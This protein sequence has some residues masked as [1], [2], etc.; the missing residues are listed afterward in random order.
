MRLKIKIGPDTKE[1]RYG[2]KIDYDKPSNVR[3]QSISF[4]MD[5]D[6]E[7][8][9]EVGAIVV[10]GDEQKEVVYSSKDIELEIDTGPMEFSPVEEAVQ[11][12][13]DTDEIQ[14]YVTCE[15][16]EFTMHQG[17]GEEDPEREETSEDDCQDG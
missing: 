2:V 9:V 4:Y 5:H 16:V 14:K 7:P 17:G 10:E 12:L 15:G 8:E 6:E 1:E 3:V 13:V 11:K